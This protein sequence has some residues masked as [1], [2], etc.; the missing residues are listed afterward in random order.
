[1][2]SEEFEKNPKDKSEPKLWINNER[3]E[4]IKCDNVSDPFSG[5]VFLNYLIHVADTIYQ[6]DE[7]H[8]TPTTLVRNNAIRREDKKIKVFSLNQSDYPLWNNAKIFAKKR[9][10]NQVRKF[11]GQPYVEHLIRVSKA[12]YRYT[13]DD[14]VLA[15]SILHEILEDTNTSALEVH[16]LFGD[17]VGALVEELTSNKPIE[18]SL[19]KITYMGRKMTNMSEDVLMI[20][21]ANRYTNLKDLPSSP[22]TPEDVRWVVTYMLETKMILVPVMK[23]K[24]WTES[25]IDIE[26]KIQGSLTTNLINII[27]IRKY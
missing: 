5:G 23:C 22:S 6:Y 7:N 27:N 25:F 19:G 26:C 18:E 17:K 21:M 1:M 24:V 20:K 9:Y 3:F 12:V 11:N 16:E 15:S 10:A 8:S 2:S 4:T 13:N 14:V